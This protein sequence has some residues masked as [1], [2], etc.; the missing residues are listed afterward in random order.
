[1]KGDGGNLKAAAFSLPCPDKL[2][3]QV[4][5]VLIGLLAFIG[6]SFGSD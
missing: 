3:G 6:I 4:R 2:W 5:I 1:M